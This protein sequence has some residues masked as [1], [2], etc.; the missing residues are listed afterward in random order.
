MVI[1]ELTFSR[2]ICAEHQNL[3]IS[4]DIE[5]LVKGVLELL[6]KQLENL[7]VRASSTIGDSLLLNEAAT[8]LLEETV[9]LVVAA[10]GIIGQLLVCADA[11]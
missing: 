10:E 1:V 7:H 6:L 3:A 2:L 11:G 5:G 9:Q 4:E 8:P